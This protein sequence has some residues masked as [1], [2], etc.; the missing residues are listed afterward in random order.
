LA[1][2]KTAEVIDKPNI[3]S[4]ITDVYD[5]APKS[6]EN[7]LEALKAHVKKYPE[8]YPLTAGKF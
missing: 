6:L 4:M 8:S 2:V 1:A 5:T 7:Q 3:D